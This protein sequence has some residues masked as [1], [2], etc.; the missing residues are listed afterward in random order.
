MEAI[1][2]TAPFRSSTAILF[3]NWN[4]FMMTSFIRIL[5]KKIHPVKVLR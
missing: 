4:P 5:E 2:A 3:R 1:A